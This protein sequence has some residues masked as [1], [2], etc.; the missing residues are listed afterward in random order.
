MVLK[1][2]IIQHFVHDLVGL[3]GRCGILLMHSAWQHIAPCIFLPRHPVCLTLMLI[4]PS[5]FPYHKADKI[6]GV[7]F[8]SPYKSVW[9]RSSAENSGNLVAEERRGP[10]QFL[11]KIPGPV[12]CAFCFFVC[13]FILMQ[14]SWYWALPSPSPKFPNLPSVLPYRFMMWVLREFSQVHHGF[15]GVSPNVIGTA[16]N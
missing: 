16:H 15:T 4:S 10:Q 2:R 9:W 8:F 6:S 3:N 7:A 11:S 5:P 13:L 12:I 14:F 1:P